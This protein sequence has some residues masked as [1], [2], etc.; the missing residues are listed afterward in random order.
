M[1]GGRFIAD[2]G[3]G[4]PFYVRYVQIARVDGV[5]AQYSKPVEEVVTPAFR[6][7]EFK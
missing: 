7:T 2:S 1:V 4:G 3:V 6:P 5:P